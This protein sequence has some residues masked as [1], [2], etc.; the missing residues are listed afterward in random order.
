MFLKILST[1]A[2]AISVASSAHA[3]QSTKYPSGPV[4]II[5]PWGAG[6]VSDALARKFGDE[7]SKR[8]G[9]PFIVE[10]RPGAAGNIGSAYVA[11]SRPDGLTLLLTADTIFTI[12]P[13]LYDNMPFDPAKDLRPVAMMGNM[14]LVLVTNP[15]TKLK[16][17]AEIIAA[18]KAN[19]GQLTFGTSG[20][21]SPS[22]LL[23]ELLQH[24]AGIKVNQIPYQ[25]NAPSVT[26][27]VAGETNALFAALAGTTQFIESGKL[28]PIALAS[29]TPWPTLPGVPTIREAGL[30][31]MD[32]VFWQLFF[33]PAGTPPDIVS[34]LN[35][36]IR[37]IA[38]MES[39][40]KLY[41]QLG[42]VPPANATPEDAVH[43]LQDDR[44]SWQELARAVNLRG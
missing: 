20:P 10:N 18:A 4:R 40:R 6:G 9:Q 30:A 14:P 17:L 37:K 36:E 3:Q 44:R 38:Q 35:E 24:R 28:Q 7:L 5:V 26:S 39:I 8:T 16:T 23:N 19:P 43:R 33:V 2:L 21:G 15:A 29:P 1:L 32:I 27:L 13:L 34:T 11:K 41:E 42:M 22:A 31:G 12:N 25:G